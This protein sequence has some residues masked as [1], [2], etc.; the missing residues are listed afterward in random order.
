MRSGENSENVT[1]GKTH[2]AVAG[3]TAASGNILRQGAKRAALTDVSNRAPLASVPAGKP[4]APTTK[5]SSLARP[6]RREVSHAA[7]ATIPEGRYVDTDVSD[8][9][10][11][12][13]ME[14]DGSSM[15]TAE[16]EAAS[17]ELLLG[18]PVTEPAY[19]KTDKVELQRV[20]DEFVD[21]WDEWGDIS[22]VQEYADDIFTYMHELEVWCQT[23]TQNHEADKYRIS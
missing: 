21:E 19:T 2:T 9:E 1:V 14:V 4:L 15:T 11:E 12:A 13:P 22:M 6:I 5:R 16:D 23:R 17:R 20:V 8:V 10:D 18:A 3:K 7:I